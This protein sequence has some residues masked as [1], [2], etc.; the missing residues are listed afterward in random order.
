[1]EPF[2]VSFR[3]ATPPIL[4]GGCTLDAVI[5]GELARCVESLEEAIR[6]TPLARTDGVHHGSSLLLLGD[7]GVAR[8]VPVVQNVRAELLSADPGAI[9]FGRRRVAPGSVKSTL[10]GYEARVCE[11]GAWLGT[12]RLDEVQSILSSVLG[13]GK[14][15]QTGWGMIEPGSL[16]VEP[17]DA[18]P[19]TFGL[20]SGP[21]DPDFAT[22]RVTPRRPLPFDLFVRLGGD[23][24]DAVA[25]IVRVRQPYYDA[26]NPPVPA[27]VPTP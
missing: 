10:N 15:R 6:A 11:G 12:G 20:V 9:A 27:V 22:A 14:R 1:M 25:A 21:G 7:T 4:R 26:A 13:I 16:E 18:D 5:G 17:V 24:L 23:P 3:F 8:P 19:A 2:V